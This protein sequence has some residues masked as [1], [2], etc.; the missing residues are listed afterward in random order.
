VFEVK[1]SEMKEYVSLLVLVNFLMIDVF[2]EKFLQ[3][4]M[5]RIKL[6]GWD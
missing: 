3:L 4:I 2:D 6:A 5:T 1:I